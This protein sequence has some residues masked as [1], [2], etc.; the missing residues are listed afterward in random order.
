LLQDAGEQL[1][2]QGLAE[3]IASE[4][5]SEDAKEIRAVGVDEIATGAEEVGEAETAN[6]VADGLKKRKK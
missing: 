3:V 6:A 5:L 4:E 1:E 2:D